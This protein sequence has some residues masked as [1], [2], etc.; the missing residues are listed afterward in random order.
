MSFC[1]AWKGSRICQSSTSEAVP[2]CP[3]ANWF[4]VLVAG[5]GGWLVAKGLM[6]KT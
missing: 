5:L 6:K 4:W 1:L 3:T 2:V